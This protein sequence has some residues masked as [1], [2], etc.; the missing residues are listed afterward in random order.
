MK[1]RI[2]AT[3]AV[4]GLMRLNPEAVILS[5]VGDKVHIWAQQG[6]AGLPRGSGSSDL[7]PSRRNS[8]LTGSDSFYYNCEL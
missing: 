4:K 7:S 5:S 2:Y 1:I 6:G 8:H 3:P